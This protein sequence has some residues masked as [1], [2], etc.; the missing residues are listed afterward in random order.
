MLGEPGPAPGAALALLGCG[1]TGYGLSLWLYLLAQ[2]RLGAARTASIF[3]LAPFVGAVVAWALA[4]TLPGP[5]QTVASALFALS[6]LLHLTEH[7]QHAHRHDPVE[8][9]H[10][11]R[12]D[13][14]HHAHA[15]SPPVQGEHTH[16]HHHEAQEHSHEH[17]PDL[18]HDHRHEG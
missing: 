16:P 12:H 10:A 1:A 6:V 17:A 13:D 9:V 14:G 4:G 3:A 5:A 15:H 11:H 8:H 7:H 2:R 18:H